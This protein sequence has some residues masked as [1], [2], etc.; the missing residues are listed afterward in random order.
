MACTSLTYSLHQE[1]H[2]VQ[3][4]G[5]GQSPALL[6]AG[7][8]SLRI[9][10]IDGKPKENI[11]GRLIMLKK[12]HSQKG[13]NLVELAIGIPVGLLLLAALAF[14][15]VAA[16]NALFHP[17]KPIELPHI[18]GMN[19]SKNEV[20][21]SEKG[22]STAGSAE[23]A[24]TMTT[25]G[26]TVQLG[27][28]FTFPGSLQNQV[29]TTEGYSIAVQN[30]KN[31]VMS[32]AGDGTGTMNYPDFYVGTEGQT[33]FGLQIIDLMVILDFDF[34]YLDPSD[35]TVK[36]MPY[37][38]IVQNA[39]SLTELIP[40]LQAEQQEVH[41][42]TT[43]LGIDASWTNAFDRDVEGF[44]ARIQSIGLPGQQ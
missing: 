35:N 42:L 23:T 26:G 21:S 22:L 16:Y 18:E 27:G 31:Q 32:I 2:L 38:I 5:C 8:Q 28:V 20:P 41:R 9:C 13:Q 29:L 24:P 14:A 36:E 11:E 19:L 40:C 7:Q 25:I 4:K 37:Q 33:K 12:H 1:V 3:P 10:Q 34:K 30:I 17:A 39:G 15:F 6:E 44:N 43:E